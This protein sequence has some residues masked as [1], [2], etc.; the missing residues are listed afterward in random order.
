MYRRAPVLTLSMAVFLLSLMGIP[1]LVGFMGKLYVFAAIVQKGP[2]YWWYAVVGAVNAAIAAYYYA[3]I[4]K[5]MIIDAGNEAKTPLRIAAPD[6]AWVVL[7][8]VANIV[9]LLFW[10]AIDGWA[11][12]SLTLYA[13]R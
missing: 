5:T 2:S 13:G 12:G 9:P 4:L 10:G 8:A 3:R 1:P 7:F 6:M 11:R